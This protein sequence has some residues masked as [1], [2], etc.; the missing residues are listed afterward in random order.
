MLGV[1]QGLTQ[2]FGIRMAQEFGAGRTDE[3]KRS[4]G[5][6]AVLSMLSAIALVAA[7]QFLQDL[8]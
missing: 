3:L 7:G 5:S 2:G 1:I 8:C 4:V 6:A